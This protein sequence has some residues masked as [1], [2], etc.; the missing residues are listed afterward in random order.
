MKRILNLLSLV[1][2]LTLFVII[3][4][5]NEESENNVCNVSNPTEELSWLKTMIIDLSDYDYIMIANY[6]GETVFYNVNCNPLVNYASTV[7]N[8]SGDVIGNT[9]DIR[10][11]LSNDRLIWKRADSKCNFND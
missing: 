9:N 11:E 5:D 10:D 8:C 1:S 6:K 4:C 3:S 7:F 2:I